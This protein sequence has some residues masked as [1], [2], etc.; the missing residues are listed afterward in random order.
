MPYQINVPTL[1]KQE[2]NVLL[3][4]FFFLKGTSA[5]HNRYKKSNDNEIEKQ[6]QNCTASVKWKHYA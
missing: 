5:L 4:V 3:F 2:D 1:Q 6:K